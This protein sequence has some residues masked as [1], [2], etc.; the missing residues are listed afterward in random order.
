MKPSEHERL[1]IKKILN[2]NEIY[3]K[4]FEITKGK[5]SFDSAPNT[6]MK[7]LKVI[8]TGHSN[9]YLYGD[10]HIHGIKKN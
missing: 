5:I 4:E 6:N 9:P 3:L 10:I 1:I 2:K 8:K 7:L